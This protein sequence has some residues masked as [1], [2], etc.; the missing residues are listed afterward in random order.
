MCGSDTLDRDSLH[1]KPLDMTRGLAQ[2]TEEGEHEWV[3]ILST[4][5]VPA[6]IMAVDPDPFM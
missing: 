2:G 3:G 5:G 1:Q 4:S 6:L